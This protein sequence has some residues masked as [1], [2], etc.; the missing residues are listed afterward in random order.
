MT[1][2]EIISELKKINY[3]NLSDDQISKLSQTL[4]SASSELTKIAYFRA[5]QTSDPDIMASA[6]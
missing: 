4:K 2:E 1:P 3:E 6:D 5:R